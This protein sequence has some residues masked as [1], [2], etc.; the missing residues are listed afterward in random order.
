MKWLSEFKET[1]LEKIENDEK[2]EIVEKIKDKDIERKKNPEW[3]YIKDIKNKYLKEEEKKENIYRKLI[4]REKNIEWESKKERDEKNQEEWD[5]IKEKNEKNKDVGANTETNN[6]LERL[7]R[8]NKE[9]KD[10]RDLEKEKNNNE[11]DKETDKHTEKLKE[12]TESKNELN[13]LNKEL[14]K[15]FEK[16]KDA[17]E[18]GNKLESDVLNKETDEH[19]EKLKED[20]K[21]ENKQD[22]REFKNMS[23]LEKMKEIEKA[24]DKLLNI[25]IE[26]STEKLNSLKE[27]LEKPLEKQIEKKEHSETHLDKLRE[28]EDR[29]IEEI[30]RDLPKLNEET[31][32][33]VDEFFKEEKEK[34]KEIL[35][36]HKKSNENLSAET[37]LERFKELKT[38]K[39]RIDDIKEHIQNSKE[40]KNINKYELKISPDFQRLMNDYHKETGK[41]ANHGLRITN[42]FI[43]WIKNNEKITD[44]K[45]IEFINKYNKINEHKEVEKYLANIL[46]SSDDSYNKIIKDLNQ[47]G[48]SISPLL[49]NRLVKE[50]NLRKTRI[51][52]KWDYLDE[53]SAL[54]DFKKEI[55]PSV[56]E[57]LR[58]KWEKGEEDGRLLSKN[59]VPTKEEIKKN[60]FSDWIS[61]IEKKNIKYNDILKAA[62]YDVNLNL[63]KWDYLDDKSALNDFK[64]EILPN[65]KE[66]LKE[67][68]E[69]GEEGGRLLSKNDV[70]TVEEIRNNGYKDWVTAIG[71]KHIK[72]NDIIRAAG[73]DVKK[74]YG[75]WD[76][77]D[78]KSALNDFKKEILPNVKESLK[79]KWEKGEE[80]GRL[81]RKNEVPTIGEIR[82]NG[83]GDWIKA[84]KNKNIK[85]NDIIKAAGYDVNLNL[86][87]W[88]YLDEKS[89]LND[90][91]KEILPNVKESLREKWEKGEEGGRLLRKNEVP[92]IGEI[93][94]NGY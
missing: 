43:D 39:E 24:V 86:G 4:D 44:D 46:K 10:D 40:I 80:D 87:K 72:Y 18:T 6:E 62:G 8:E 90:F 67:K 77:L 70:P 22:I 41:W 16:L 74:H 50:G 29:N 69:K 30:S 28:K 15:H 34:L 75:K 89:A 25:K 5:Y 61:A 83:Y 37:H 51:M 88:D 42:K 76:Y 33:E 71:K 38:V 60:D 2:K 21:I 91:K 79:E 19:I 13:D 55:L 93:R 92:T 27:H 94:E 1:N 31:I 47:L 57:S 48:L 52:H 53:K 23:I 65:V 32:K 73:Y 63:G 58:E 66:S 14:D 20:E 45:K 7:K 78:D 49:L 85:Y 54:N 59:D 17:E 36:D 68:W 81:L 64:K 84:V 56:K 12:E 82:E 35:V 26:I 9:E 11:L 3:E